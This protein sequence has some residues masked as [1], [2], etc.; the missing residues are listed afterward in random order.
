MSNERLT[1]KTCVVLVWANTVRTAQHRVMWS[2]AVLCDI[3]S[4]N[5][6]RNRF[7]QLVLPSRWKQQGLPKSRQIFARLQGGILQKTALFSQR[8]ENFKY[9]NVGFPHILSLFIYRVI[10]DEGKYFWR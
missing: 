9:E 10:Q 2:S 7:T 6:R 8:R 4:T 1:L 3:Y 5:F